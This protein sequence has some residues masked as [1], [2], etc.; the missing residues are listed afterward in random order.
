MAVTWVA[1][2]T[3]AVTAS[4]TSITANAPAGI[5]DG[6][7]LLAAVFGRSALTTPSGWTKVC[8]TAV[9]NVSSLVQRLAV[10]SKNTVTSADASSSFTFEQASAERMGVVYAVA[11]G[12]TAIAEYATETANNQ[13]FYAVFD[14][15]EELIESGWAITPDALTAD[16]NGQMLLVF[17]SAIVTGDA[18]DNWTPPSSFTRFSGGAAANYRVAGAYR[19]VDNGQS[20]SGDLK[21]VSTSANFS[22]PNGLGAITLRLTADGGI[23]PIEG[24]IASTGPLGAPSVLGQSVTAGRCAAPSMLGAPRL[25]AWHD[26]SAFVADLRP[27]YVMDLTAEEDVQR[28][29]ISSW[30]ATLQTNGQCFVQCVVPACEPYTDAIL[31]ADLFVISRVGVIRG[32]PFEYEMARATPGA[33][34]LA[35]GPERFTATL[36]GYSAAFAID[37]GLPDSL[38]RTL[39]DVRS[40]F[41]ESNGLRV[42]CAVD[43]LLRPGMRAIV[44]GST[45]TVGRINYY[46]S[47]GDQYM[48]VSEAEEST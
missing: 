44:N 32:A 24:Y 38:D 5:A 10:F 19:L 11:R 26:F 17:G 33:P 36:Q 15:F 48:D 13:A 30:Q 28:I 1:G 22:T 42:R 45:F 41:T 20:N 2:S 27:V 29:P 16:A 46:V 8:E 31:A 18:S 47:G 34:Q 7:M 12:A 6:D 39:V 25:K 9:F 23:D 3:F 37:D 43:W 14:E 4:A 35:Q 40:I 21:L